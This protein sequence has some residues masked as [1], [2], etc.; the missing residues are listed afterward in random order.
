MICLGS[1][2]V[3]EIK[4]VVIT[5]GV[6][7]NGNIYWVWEKPFVEKLRSFTSLKEAKK[8]AQKLI[9]EK[10]VRVKGYKRKSK[11]VVRYAPM[12]FVKKRWVSFPNAHSFGLKA[13]AKKFIS[14]TKK[15][16]KSAGLTVPRMK[17]EKIY[18]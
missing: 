1:K 5:R 12:A 10:T 16:Y 18:V 14:Q 13:N 3:L 7:K 6:S 8:Y 4:N 9:D 17:V 15:E 11:S 2:K